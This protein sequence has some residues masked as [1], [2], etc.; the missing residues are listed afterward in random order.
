MHDDNTNHYT[1]MSYTY[2]PCRLYSHTGA[3]LRDVVHLVNTRIIET[4]TGRPTSLLT[5]FTKYIP[6]YT[7]ALTPALTHSLIPALTPARTHS[8][9]PTYNHSLPH[10]LAYSRTHS[11]TH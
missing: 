5:S 6:T 11:L 7:R 8:Y 2:K 9:T 1:C 3:S 4:R 10:L